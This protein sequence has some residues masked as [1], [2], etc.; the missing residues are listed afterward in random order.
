[1]TRTVL[2]DVHGDQSF[3]TGE[4]ADKPVVLAIVGDD[5]RSRYVEILGEAQQVLHGLAG[6]CAVPTCRNNHF[7]SIDL[8]G[9]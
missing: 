6:V 3:V 7:E 8:A 9:H 1:M 2:F 4:A 5:D